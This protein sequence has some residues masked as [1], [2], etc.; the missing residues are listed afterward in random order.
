MGDNVPH[1]GNFFP[2]N[3]GVLISEVFG[4][5]FGGFADDDNAAKDSILFF[6]VYGE[7]FGCNAFSILSDGLDGF[8]NVD[9]GF[10]VTRHK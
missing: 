6:D 1:S 4:E 2:G 10:L 9:E 8:N 5:S 3:A 7:G